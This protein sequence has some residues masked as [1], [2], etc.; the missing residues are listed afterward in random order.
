MVQKTEKEE[1]EFKVVPETITPCVNNCG[2]TGNPATNHMCQKCFAATAGS[3]SAASVAIPHK[4]A[5]KT[6]R[7]TF[8][9]SSPGRT[10]PDLNKRDSPERIDEKSEAG[11]PSPVKREVNRC[12]GCNRK[13]GL[14]GFRCRCGEL[15]CGEHR[16]SDRHDCSYDYKSA[17]RD[18]IAKENPV[19]RAAK[20]FKL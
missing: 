9:R 2:V 7:S 18:A 14:T 15:F 20:I 16:Y 10:V 4:F 13:V 6:P 11:S 1:T 19:V 8:R 12:S 3:V 17:G 5:E